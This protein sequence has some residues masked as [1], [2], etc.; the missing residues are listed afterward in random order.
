[1]DN[2]SPQ[3]N[4]LLARPWLLTF[5]PINA[6]TSGFGVALPL[7][8]LITLRAAWAQVALAATVFNIAVI[9]AS[10]LWGYLADRY[11]TRRRFLVFS[12]LGIAALYLASS[13]VHSF[14]NLL[15]LYAVVGVLSPAGVSASNLLILEQFAERD[16][17]TA[18]G[19]FQEMSIIGSLA[20]LLVGY[21][22]LATHHPLQ[23]LLFVL[24]GLAAASVVAVQVGIKDSVVRAKTI[25]VARH[26]ESL[27]SRIRHLA[28]L[29]ISV[30]FFP[31]RPSLKPGSVRRFRTWLRQEVHHELPLILAAS[32][33]FNLSSNL[34]NISYTPYLY[35]IGISAASIFLV[36]FSNNLAQGIAFPVSGTLSDRMGID[37]LVQRST[38]VR[39]LGYLAVAGFTFVPFLSGGAA[40]GSNAIAYGVLG[41][42]IAFYSTSSSLILFRALEGR[43]AGTLLGLNS[44]LGGIAAVGGAGLS[45]IL[46]LFGSYRWTFLVSAGALLASLPL[47]SAAHLASSRR[48]PPV[49]ESDRVDLASLARPES[50]SPVAQVDVARAEID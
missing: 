27:A 6:A 32:L 17:A 31:K 16:R 12:Y 19:S 36:N 29:H 10:M 38:Y 13:L 9:L 25:H 50:P 15:L 39:S 3:M 45:G 48:H 22:W 49:A 37:R 30:P 44:A 26:P 11:P 8:I 42:A 34:F 24:A 23:P 7:L 20:G 47:W 21:V 41:G 14:S 5:V 1:M 28:P 4:R 2:S 46:A 18:F 33:L 40:F 43:D 35:S